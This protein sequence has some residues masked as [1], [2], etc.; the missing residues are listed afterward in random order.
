MAPFDD[1]TA[2]SPERGPGPRLRIAVAGTGISGLAAAWLLAARHD[3]TVYEKN[4]RPGGHSNTVVA[5]CPEGDVPVDTGFIVYNEANYPNLTAMFRYLGV[6]TQE[7][8]MSFAA[9]LE[10]GGK[11][12]FEYSG[13]GLNGIFADRRN[14]VSPRMWRMISEI[15]KLYRAAPELAHVEGLD[16]K[17]LGD[18]LREQGYSASLCDDHL[19]PMCAAIWSLPVERVEQFPA[20]AFLRFFDNHGLMRLKGRPVWRTVAGGSREYV[21]KLAAPLEG[22]IRYGAGIADVR[23]DAGGVTVTDETGASERYDHIVI[24]S[25]SDEALAMLGDAD[26]DERR[27]LG[28][29]PYQRNVAWLHSD[30]SF[31]PQERRVWASWNYMGGGA[32][33]PVCVSYWMNRLQ[34][35]PTERQLFVTLNPS[36]EP[37]PGSV[38]TRIDYDH[39]VF[40]AGAFAA[41]RRLWQLQGKRRTWFCGAYFGSG[42]HEDGLQAG[43]AVAEELGGVR[44]PWAVENASGRIHLGTAAKEAA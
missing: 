14:I 31:M 36:Q 30:E 27:L 10:T 43:L 12:R 1:C 17:P 39:P 25:H 5:P 38:V 29:M 41:Q 24:G 32:G 7:S 4:E 18:F 23:R 2:P 20:L 3:V 6:E 15:V 9:S 8:N 19:L 33:S 11:R 26:G 28:A 42:F 16:R 44:R 13:S 22:R 34:N 40:D 37:A 35:L 21:K